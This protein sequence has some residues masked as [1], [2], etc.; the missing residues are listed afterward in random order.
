[1]ID[2]SDLDLW[3]FTDSVTEAADFLDEQIARQGAAPETLDTV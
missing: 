1:M 2:A 3:L